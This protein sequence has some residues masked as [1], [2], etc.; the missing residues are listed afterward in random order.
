MPI[1]KSKSLQKMIRYTPQNQLS[2]EGFETPFEKKL[3]PNNRW[4]KL[5]E[6]LPWDEMA[7]IYLRCLSKKM[8][9]PSV[10]ARVVIGALIVKHRLKLSDRETIEM[11]QENIYL[12]YFLGYS[13]FNP[14]PPFDASLFVTLRKRMG[15]DK[16]DQMNC[17]I[18]E[19]AKELKKDETDQQDDS[20]AGSQTSSKEE[21]KPQPKNQG[22]LKLDATVADQMIE[23]PTDLKLLNQ[24]RLETERIID[25][26]Y[27]QSKRLI[28][29]RTYRRV[30]RNQY[31]AIAKKRN[32]QKKTIR[33]GLRQQ[34]GYVR[35]NIK[36]IDKLLDELS[37]QPFPLTFR[38]LRL[39]W[40]IQH[41]YAQQK[42]MYDHEVK[43]HPDRIVNIY[44]PYVRPIPRGKDK[45]QTEFGAKLGVSEFDGFCRLD[46]ISWDAYNECTDLIMQ[47]E[48]YKDLHGYY[49]EVVLVDRIYL[50]QKNR[51]WLKSK[52]I[53][54]AGKPLGRPKP[55]NAYFKRKLQKERN[56]RNHVEG[57]FGQGKNAYE[58]SRIRARRKDTSESWISTIF[59]VMNLM[60]WLKIQPAIIYLIISQILWWM[61][62]FWPKTV[63]RLRSHGQRHCFP[64]I[65]PTHSWIGEPYRQ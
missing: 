54:H 36:T 10:D 12:Q 24:A 33:R 59:L 46:H 1:L 41:L 8:G 51:K 52:G 19:K 6:R 3:D 43:S 32:R 11:V 17:R 63:L 62:I 25:I 22:K 37:T 21:A 34:L 18:I 9:R 27:E 40:V 58:L 35:R 49:P 57:K 38:D 60:R 50:T 42:F 53:R 20:S 30:A 5:A 26:L 65:I 39:Y 61:A 44:Q 4:V 2:L 47:V 16:F 7:Q 23:Y 64:E 13:S 48:A 28:K 29:P 55:L 15:A 45:G 56:M 31:L 14:E